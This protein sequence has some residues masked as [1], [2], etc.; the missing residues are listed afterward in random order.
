MLVNI[1]M[2][3]HQDILNGFQVTERTRFC[4][5]QTTRAKTACLPTLK[6]RDI[7]IRDIINYEERI[8]CKQGNHTRY[9]YSCIGFS[10]FVNKMKA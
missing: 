1:Y 5:G 7:I 3:F 9:A 8:I 4:D 6:G 10:D 2:K